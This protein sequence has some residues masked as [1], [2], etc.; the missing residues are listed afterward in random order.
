M[1]WGQSL[2]HTMD[3]TAVDILYI[4]ADMPHLPFNSGPGPATA[5]IPRTDPHEQE[6]VPRPELGVQVP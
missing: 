5:A 4:P 1:H 6:S 3:F 2:E